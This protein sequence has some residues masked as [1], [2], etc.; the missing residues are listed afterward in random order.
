MEFIRENSQLKSDEYLALK[1]YY[2][3]LCQRQVSV[4]FSLIT[5][6]IKHI[7]KSPDQGRQIKFCQ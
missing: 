7:L 1:S 4:D 6:V 5:L 3:E 2:S